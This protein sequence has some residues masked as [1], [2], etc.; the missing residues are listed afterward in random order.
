MIIVNG[1]I[2]VSPGGV[3]KLRGAIGALLAATRQEA[4]CVSYVL[5]A[6]LEEPDLIRVSEVWESKE[7]MKAHAVAPHAASF[8]AT[9]RETGVQGMN[10]K[11][12]EGE[13][14]RQLLGSD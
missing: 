14:W 9:L 3:E 2:R 4:G 7:A 11:A 10:V 13:F 6:D 1:W 8:G 5:S 12:Y